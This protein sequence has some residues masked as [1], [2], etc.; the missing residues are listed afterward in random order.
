MGLGHESGLST[1]RTGHPEQFKITKTWRSLPLPGGSNK[2]TPWTSMDH[3]GT[4]WF[5]NKNHTRT[6]KGL[7]PKTWQL[8]IVN[9]G[10]KVCVRQLLHLLHPKTP[11]W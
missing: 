7:V 10:P 8:G 11:E 5:K 4:Q 1:V 9:V 6:L 2:I 3:R